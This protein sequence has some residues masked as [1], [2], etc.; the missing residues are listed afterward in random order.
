[1]ISFIT[2]G[3]RR[4]VMLHRSPR[5]YSNYQGPYIIEPPIIDPLQNPTKSNPES[6]ILILKA[7]TVAKYRCG[8]KS[9]PR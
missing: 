2:I 4:M 5:A 1:M 8:M 6:P 7:C 9:I 3:F